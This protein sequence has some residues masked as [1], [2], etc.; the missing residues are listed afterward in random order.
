MSKNRINISVV[1]AIVLMLSA[2]VLIAVR[3]AQ[4]QPADAPP[5]HKLLAEV[6]LTSGPF[7]G[8]ELAEFGL[9]E[10]AVIHL[11]L[12]L[13]NI[14][15]PTFAL[16]LAGEDGSRY[17]ILQAED[18]RTNQDGGGEWQETL[19]PGAYRLVLDAAPSPGWLGVYMQTTP[20]SQ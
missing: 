11:H 10:T 20:V 3:Q 7:A 19:P 14:A 18:Y 13:Q 5:G 1:V 12:S 15:T 8:T 2:A 17:A 9:T 6:E 4:S 16:S